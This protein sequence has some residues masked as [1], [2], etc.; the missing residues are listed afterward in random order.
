[1][2]PDRAAAAAQSASFAAKTTCRYVL[3]SVDHPKEYAM[4][5]NIRILLSCF[6][7]AGMGAGMIACSAPEPPAPAAPPVAETTMPAAP[8]VPKTA[9]ANITAL[10][11]VE[12][13]GEVQL[14]QVGEF[15]RI[16]AEIRGLADGLYGFHIHSGSDCEE[17]GG[18]YNPSNSS[19]GSPDEPA[20]LRHVGDLGNLV[21][22][23]G[24]ARYHRIDPMITLDGAHGV[25]GRIA[26]IH[27]GQDQL[28]PQPAGDSGQQIGCGPIVAGDG[29]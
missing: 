19:H 20:E 1:M 11:D 4:R 9:A 27:N 3:R 13:D 23:D 6:L 14:E 17:R 18:H 15:V 7:G 10:A 12:I 24:V 5:S 25:T 21:S 8:P 16:D 2:S 28:L 26:V 22:R 29:S